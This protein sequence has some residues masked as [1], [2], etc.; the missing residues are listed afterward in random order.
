MARRAG[1]LVLPSP[2]L[3]VAIGAVLTLTM[4]LLINGRKL[5]LPRNLD[6]FG[7]RRALPILFWSALLSTTGQLAAFSA[8]YLTGATAAAVILISLDPLFMLLASRF[9]VGKSELIT[10]RTVLSMLITMGGCAIAIAL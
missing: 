8:L 1:L 3:G 9:V 4:L 7:E 5:G 2:A 6:Y 10:A